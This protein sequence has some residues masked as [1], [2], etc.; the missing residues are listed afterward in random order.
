MKGSDVDFLFILQPDWRHGTYEQCYDNL[1]CR[2]QLWEFKLGN[3]NLSSCSQIRFV[4]VA[5]CTWHLSGHAWLR[6]EIQ[7]ESSNRALG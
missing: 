1:S 2:S 3:S 7:S 5:S 4:S 6:F